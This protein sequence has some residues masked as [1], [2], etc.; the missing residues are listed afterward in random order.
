M[1]LPLSVP[2]ALHQLVGGIPGWKGHAQS[3]QARPDS[4]CSVRQWP[5]HCP[6]PVT[7]VMTPGM[8]NWSSGSPGDRSLDTLGGPA[9]AARMGLSLVEADG[10]KHAE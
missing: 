9:A 7:P 10:G 1:C 4:T 5:Y 6:W 8:M 2:S 3:R